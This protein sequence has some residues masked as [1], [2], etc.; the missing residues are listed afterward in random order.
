MD[1]LKNDT[2]AL[3][4]PKLDVFSE[5]FIRVQIEALQ[6]EYIL[7]GG[8]FPSVITDTRN[9]EETVLPVPSS[10]TV[11]QSGLPGL[12][13]QLALAEWLRAKGIRVLLAQYGV[14]GAAVAPACRLAGVRLIVH[15]HGF[16]ASR[17]ST[18]KRYAA[19]YLEMFSVA[20]TVVGVSAPM[21]AQLRAIGCPE[22]KIL[23]NPYGVQEQF[24]ALQPPL[25]DPVF[26][27]VG[28]F[29][30]KK[31]PLQTIEAFRAVHSIHPEAR[32]WMAGDGPLLEACRDA[33]R[34]YGLEKE[35][36]F[37]GILRHDMVP[38]F[39]QRG[40]AFVQ[41]SVQAESGDSEGTPVAILEA[42]AAGLPVI[43]TRHAGI[44]EAVQDGISGIL[45]Q[46]GDITGMS[47]AMRS[48][49]ETPGLARR[50]GDAGRRHI[51]ERYAM[52]RYLTTLKAALSGDAAP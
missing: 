22:S 25:Q 52:K 31:G 30:E 29:V 11:G 9:R 14:C 6:P 7:H 18:L 19:A 43:S 44:P 50:M 34:R 21:C 5:S 36:M 37:P 12:G 47:E 28:R 38:A 17:Q 33:V 49:L 41:H 46:E 42:S 45:V 13:H 10:E 32:L 51:R 1:G 40:L 39:L 2:L 3:V 20:E 16:D 48:L 35:V 27:A 24:L 15:F 4:L 8:V 26:V 23:H